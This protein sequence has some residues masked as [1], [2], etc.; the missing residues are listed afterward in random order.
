MEDSLLK[1]A[2]AIAEQKEPSLTLQIY[3]DALDA[4]PY[5]IGI[6]SLEQKILFMN[7]RWVMVRG[8]GKETWI[9]EHCSI[10]GSPHCGTD[11]CSVDRLENGSTSIPMLWEGIHYNVEAQYLRGKD[12]EKIGIIKTISRL[13]DEYDQLTGLYNRKGFYKA[14]RK[15][16]DENPNREYLLILTDIQ[17]FKMINE[18][19][20]K[21]SGDRSLCQ[22]ADWLKDLAGEES[23]L[24]HL[25]SDHFLICIPDQEE[26]LQQII[27][28]TDREIRFSQQSIGLRFSMGIY[29][30]EDRNVPVND[31]YESVNMAIGTIKN[32]Y[33]RYYVFYNEEMRTRFL[34]EQELEEDARTAFLEGQFDVYYQPVYN[35]ENE[36][37][38]SAEALVRWHHP[39]RGLVSPE[40]FIQ[41]FEK[42]GFIQELDFY[43]WR[44]VCEAIRDQKKAGKPIVPISVNL[45]RVDFCDEKMCEKLFAIAEECGVEHEYL[46]VEITETAYTDDSKQLLALVETM[47]AVGIK[48][49]MDDFGSG[50]SSL[51]ALKDI[52]VDILKIDLKFLEDFETNNRAGN[53]IASVVRMA[54]WLKL[55]VIAEGVE[56]KEQAEFLRSIG[57]SRI[58]GYYYTK[59]LTREDFQELLVNCQ[60]QKDEQYYRTLEQLDFNALWDANANINIL[61]QGMIGGMGLYEMIGNQLE[62]VRVNNGYYEVM[63]GTANDIFI[64]AGNAFAH[65]MDGDKD[66]LLATCRRSMK[67]RQVETIQV[68]RRR[69]DGIPIWVEVK[70]RYLGSSGNRSAFYFA[71]NDITREKKLVQRIEEQNAY[72]DTI[73]DRVDGVLS[74]PQLLVVDDSRINRMILQKQLV[75]YYEIVEAENG[76]EALQVIEQSRG[77]IKLILLDLIMPVMDGYEFMQTMREK[78]IAPNVPILVMTG[79]TGEDAKQRSIQLGASDFLQKPFEPVAMRLR[80]HNLIRLQ[81]ALEE[82]ERMQERAEK[83]ALTSLLNRATFEEKVRAIL[84]EEETSCQNAFFIID[85]DDFKHINDSL[86]HSSGDEVLKKTGKRLK[87]L[88][89]E[90]DIIGRLGGD[91]LVVFME[92]DAA[93]DVVYK[94]GVEVCATLSRWRKEDSEAP[95][96]CSAGIACSPI[97]GTTFEELYRCADL[98]LYKSKG[99]GKNKCTLYNYNAAAIEETDSTDG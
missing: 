35:V 64:N 83:D 72:I 38:L 51:N 81:R 16:L 42:I 5:S 86:G 39:E 56:T 47:Q 54:K 77:R 65:V 71:I 19:F 8:I 98:A 24:A 12:G 78:N 59:P 94:K 58:Q 57:C 46:R 23:I 75:Q 43:V 73:S 93:P 96:T 4:I 17:R 37:I 3:E 48:V 13:S 49:L 18:L 74:K 69:F 2:S 20:G 79:E 92:G 40:D 45:S 76:R 21:E 15:I 33:S 44:N 80:I 53:I 36:R 26:L 97:H 87:S 99:Q 30:I 7:K 9:G 28:A 22:F 31:M 60:V 90:R 68:Q 85:I 29:R 50:Y 70:I 6:M 66:V 67:T 25:D 95:F 52:P 32:D 82:K 89:R 41:I 27:E 1:L 88:F 11:K 34:M 55:S 61:F 10:T 84:E 14:L 91:E 62:I 63:G